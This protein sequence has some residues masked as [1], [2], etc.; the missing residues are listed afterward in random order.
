MHILSHSQ[1][2]GLYYIGEFTARNRADSM[3]FRYCLQD[4][5]RQMAYAVQHLKYFLSRHIDRRAEVHNY[6]NKVE[7]VLAY[8]EE[9]DTPLREALIILLG[10]GLG[11]EQIAD[12]AAKLEYFKGRW[13]RDYLA[14][15]AAGGLNDRAKRLHPSLRKYATQPTEAQAA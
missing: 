8:E 7:A 9:Q 3:I 1:L 10:G 12:G 13:V 6:L 15:L 14:R 11:K 2:M 4:L 5:A